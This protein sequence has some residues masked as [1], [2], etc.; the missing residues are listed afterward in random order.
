MSRFRI[1]SE[2]CPT[3][4]FL[5]LLFLFVTSFAFAEEDPIDAL[6]RQMAFT[7]QTMQN[8]EVQRAT[9]QAEHEAEIKRHLALEKKRT[10]DRLAIQLS[11]LSGTLSGLP[12]LPT[13]EGKFEGQVADDKPSPSDHRQ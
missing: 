5:F 10:E 4:T 8:L 3:G 12:E 7:D 13:F 9:W 2:L 11:G 6:N 1:A